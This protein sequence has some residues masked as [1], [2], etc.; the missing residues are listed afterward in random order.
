M[1]ER[2]R[3]AVAPFRFCFGWPQAF[4]EL[5][6]PLPNV[7]HRWHVGDCKK[8]DEASSTHSVFPQVECD[9]TEESCLWKPEHLEYPSVGEHFAKSR[10]SFWC[11]R[12]HAADDRNKIGIERRNLG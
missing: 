9:L 4:V 12:L 2:R 3:V 7:C 1:L 5:R 6:I 10:D 8:R 11:R